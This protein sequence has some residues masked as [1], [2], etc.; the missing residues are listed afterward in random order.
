MKWL[1]S[2]CAI[3][4]R[5]RDPVARVRH[6]TSRW[7]LQLAAVVAASA[8][9]LTACSG[10]DSEP[11]ED[12]ETSNSSPAE[13]TATAA[14]YASIVAKNSNLNDVLNEMQGCDWFSGGSLDPDPA[15][16]ACRA[17]LTTMS[18]ASLS[19]SS[20]LNTASDPAAP[21]YIGQPPAELMALVASTTEAAENLADAS[22][23]A[24]DAKCAYSGAGKCG[25]LRSETFKA[26]G[27]MER[28]LAAWAPYL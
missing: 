1:A 6:V 14:Q 21:D 11:P 22:G 7:K 27:P 23:R 17:G 28:E 12:A 24:S 3:F 20:N 8:W 10:A 18:Y 25:S 4:H 2:G 19:L 9:S 26:M 16:I 13:E 15:L 5:N